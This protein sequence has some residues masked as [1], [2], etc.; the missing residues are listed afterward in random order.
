MIDDHDDEPGLT[1]DEYLDAVGRL[2][3]ADHDHADSRVAHLNIARAAR[4]VLKL[5][6]EPHPADIYAPTGVLA[7]LSC[8]A[9]ARIT[10]LA[11]ARIAA[12]FITSANADGR[13]AYEGFLYALIA[14]GL[15][16]AHSR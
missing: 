10:A 12:Q 9:C 16:Q 3:G 15:D 7:E 13:E 2:L 8:I 1:E 6:D 5:L 4:L 11:A 14:S